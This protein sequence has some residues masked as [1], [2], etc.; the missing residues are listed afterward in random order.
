[1]VV[2]N[3]SLAATQVLRQ[4]HPILG[5]IPNWVTRGDYA[6]AKPSSD[7]YRVAV[8]RFGAGEPYRIG[9]ENTMSG[10]AALRGIATHIYYR[11]GTDMYGYAEAASIANADLVLIPDFTTRSIL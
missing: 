4:A 10:V 8:E 6:A 9:V 2:T 7:A 3:S 1:M 5:R 11:T